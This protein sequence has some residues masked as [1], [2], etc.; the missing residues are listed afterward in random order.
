MGEP[1]PEHSNLER[2]LAYCFF[3]EHV[4][5]PCQLAQSNQT[6][7]HLAFVA[8]MQLSPWFSDDCL[9]HRTSTTTLP[10]AAAPLSSHTT[11][12]SHMHLCFGV[13]TR[14]ITQTGSHVHHSR[15]GGLHTRAPDRSH[16]PRPRQKQD[17][18]SNRP[19]SASSSMWYRQASLTCL[20][21]SW[22]PGF[23]WLSESESCTTLFGLLAV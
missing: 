12:C 18:Q 9:S 5:F 23:C 22:T 10:C 1:P 7:Q 6:W 4:S 3:S 20:P 8:V 17:H 19:V 16:I 21:A 14:L 11:I 15:C 13:C 2:Q